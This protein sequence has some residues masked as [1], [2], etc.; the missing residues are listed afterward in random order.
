MAILTQNRRR[1]GGGGVWRYNAGMSKGYA[2]LLT[3]LCDGQELPAD[4][5]AAMMRAI[6]GGEWTSAQIAGALVALK[7]KGETPGELAACAKAMRELAVPV[8][9]QSKNVVDACG[10]GGDGA[11]AYNI[12]TAAAL[13]A[14]ACGARV[15]KHGNRAVS[16]ASGSFDVLAELGMPATLSADACARL[17]DETGFGFMFAP[18]HHAA[19]KHAMPARRELGVRTLFNLLGPLANPAGARRQLAGV[20]AREWL[21]PYAEALAALGAERAIVAHGDGLDELTIAGETDLAEVKDGA[22][23]R[24]TIAP[25]D[26]GLPRGKIENLRVANPQEAKDMLLAVVEGKERGDARNI[27]LL[28]AAGVLLVAGLAESLEDGAKQA[29]A[30]IDD[31][32]A[33]QTLNNFLSLA[34]QLA[35]G[36]PA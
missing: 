31:G 35:D 36:K 28:N 1:A 19:I 33:S 12:S 21:L 2:E 15:A 24:H 23:T 8:R 4:E 29:A 16:G 26:A 22:V 6:L 34:R 30:A 13:V 5:A 32:R 10:T 9:P 17:I 3:K 20:F 18:N 7:I 11:G 27:A 25:E 14:A